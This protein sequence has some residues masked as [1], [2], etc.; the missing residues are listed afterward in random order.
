MSAPEPPRR[1]QAPTGEWQYLG[2]D[3]YWYEESPGGA[4]APRHAQTPTPI[5]SSVPTPA[6][7]APS[8]DASTSSVPAGGWLAIVGSF[9]V[10]LGTVLPWVSAS[11]LIVTVNRNAFQLGAN[12][13]LT[14]VGPVLV[15][16]AVVG[17]A[18]GVARLTRSSVPR[19]MQTSAV[20]LGFAMLLLV[21]LNYPIRPSG[22][23][24]AVIWSVTYG[25]WICA[26]GAAVVIVAGFTLRSGAEKAEKEPPNFT[27]G[28]N[29]SKGWYIDPDDI[30][31]LRWWDGSSFTNRKPK[32]GWYADPQMLGQLRWYTGMGWSEKTKPA[33]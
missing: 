23:G 12:E 25:F 13:S 4:H 2:A 31:R 20:V 7:A 22:L 9:L 15:I 26:I 1:R 33:N 29:G 18:I 24:S 30:N 32:S 6:Q 3:G 5:S 17:V 16:L 10:G 14:A 11:A 28:Q 21:V 8:H 27:M 19:G